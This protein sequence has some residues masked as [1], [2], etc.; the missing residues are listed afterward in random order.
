MVYH[1]TLASI[2]R[3]SRTGEKDKRLVLFSREL[4]KVTAVAH[5]TVVP[6]A[7]WS[8]SFEPFSL[9]YVRL[10][11]RS[12]FLTVVSSEERVVYTSISTSLS[13]SLKTMAM[14]QL[15]ECVLEPSSPEPGLF[16]AYVTALS[17]M[18]IA[19]DARQ[20]DKIFLQYTLDVLTDLGFGVASLHCDRCG[21]ALD[22]E[23]SFSMR[24]NAFHC[25]RCAVTEA[26]VVLS[27]Q[28]AAFLR[29]GDGEIDA[30]HAR[31]GIALTLRLLGVAA[32]RL[33]IVP[34]F[35]QFAE[36]AATLFREE[37][38]DGQKE[39]DNEL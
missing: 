39:P 28:L 14:N 30:R 5:G 33:G 27:P 17:R 26:D 13:R 9:L 34:A 12:R 20:E 8:S 31:A 3:T 38:A 18:N 1:W 37:S 2:L 10:Y 16:A 4:G 32:A 36:N 19:A 35:E 25:R 23:P 15:T 6:E 24:D 7:K 21:S 22:A 11:D 29:A